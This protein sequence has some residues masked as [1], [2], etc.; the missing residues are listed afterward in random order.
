MRFKKKKQTVYQP[1]IFSQLW[2]YCHELIWGPRNVH[3]FQDQ[4]Q[5]STKIENNTWIKSYHVPITETN[6][7]IENSHDNG[8]KHVI[9]N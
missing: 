4:G 6:H 2:Y 3:S 5:P 9:K 1:D 7:K 8:G